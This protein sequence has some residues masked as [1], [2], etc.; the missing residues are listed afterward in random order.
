LV[1]GYFFFWTIHDDFPPDPA[2]AGPG[3]FWPGLATLALLLAWAATIAARE[4]NRRGRP[5][6]LRGLLLLAAFLALAGGGMLLWGPYVTGLDPKAHVYPAIV[7]VLV[8]W[9]AAHAAL[10]VVMQLYCVA[11]SWAGRLTPRY[12]IDIWNVALFWHFLAITAVVTFATVAL[13]P[14]VAGGGT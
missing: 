7:W 14:T 6:A 2:T 13:F 8:L 10:G 11:R 12:D 3:L 9:T 4:L 1:F 5:G